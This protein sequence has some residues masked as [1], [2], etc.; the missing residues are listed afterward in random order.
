VNGAEAT[1]PSA[2]P[3]VDTSTG[4]LVSQLSD[5]ASRL[6]RDELRLAQV[7]LKDSARHAGLG[8]GLF[9]TAGLLGVFGLATLTATAII[10][11]DLVLPLWSAALIVTVVLFIAAGIAALAGKK[12]VEEVSPTPE[13]TV[14]SVKRDVREVK[15]SRSHDH[16]R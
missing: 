15:E 8:A 13:R 16:A 6:V 12:Q 5:Q 1:F 3:S 2:E 4:Q 9:S 14:E 7:E 11:L 10:A